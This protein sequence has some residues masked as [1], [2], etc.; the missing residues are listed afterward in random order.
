MSFYFDYIIQTFDSIFN[1]ESNLSIDYG[2]GESD[3]SIVNL[4]ESFFHTSEP[5]PASITWKE[6][7]NTRIPFIGSEDDSAPIVSFENDR[8][9][10]NYDI[11]G[12][13]FYFL[14]GWQ[15]IHSDKRD[16]FGRF[17]YRESFQ[18]QHDLMTIPV[19]NYYFDILR[20]VMERLSKKSVAR[21]LWPASEYAVSLS[22]DIDKINSG[23]LE[24]GY[25]EFKKGRIL[26]ALKIFSSKVFDKDPWENINEIVKLESELGVKSTFFFITEKGGGNADYS[27]SQ[28]R[29]Y[30]PE[31]LSLNSEI[32]L[33]GSLGS[34]TDSKRISKE[35]HALDHNAVGNRFHFLMFDPAS[36]GTIFNKTKLKYDASL[37]FAEHIGFRN[38][39][40]FPFYPYDHE[41]KKAFNFVE[42]PLLIMDATLSNPI[43]MGLDKNQDRKVGTVVSEIKKFHGLLTILWHNNYFSDFKYAGWREKYVSLI[44]SSKINNAVFFTKS[45]VVDTLEHSHE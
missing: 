2:S 44:E 26:S 23:W 15:E 43:Y 17:P 35:V 1:N 28:V 18:F 29:K 6:W 33:H 40:C 4:S 38:G 22:H 39:F 3:I 5:S 31:I 24:G 7:D 11:I 34:S 20:S 27:I 25:S 8:A 37:G 9:I 45:E 10:I 19:V 30:F 41:N 21:N 12:S 42:I 16:E 14:S 32:A 36:H 13:A